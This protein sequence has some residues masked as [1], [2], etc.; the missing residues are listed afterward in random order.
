MHVVRAGSSSGEK[1]TFEIINCR[2]ARPSLDK[3][4]PRYIEHAARDLHS[5]KEKIL[6]A[7]NPFEFPPPPASPGS[8]W[9]RDHRTV[10]R[11]V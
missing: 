8:G 5:R 2:V 6:T 9:S 7:F 4:D 11:L 1:K 10:V 3:I